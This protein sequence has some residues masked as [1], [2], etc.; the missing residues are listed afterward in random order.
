[1]VLGISVLLIVLM[2][3]ALILAI[4]FL[5]VGLI[6]GRKKGNKEEL[7]VQPATPVMQFQGT[8][9][10]KQ[11]KETDNEKTISI[12]ESQPVSI[13]EEK[14]EILNN[15][16]N[17]EIIKKTYISL[18]DISNPASVFKAPIDTKITVGRSEGD[19]IISDDKSISL[20]HCEI[21]KKDGVFTLRDL[22]SS[23]G[24]FVNGNRIDSVEIK[25]GDL[26]KMGR[27]EFRLEI[28]EE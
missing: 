9:S 1:M 26:I 28:N 8:V 7:N 3:I 5:I 12:F 24:T 18:A 21:E 10:A 22:N 23:N 20:K 6:L 17:T 11:V 19:I 15:F 16:V 2:V 27:M 14:T 13:P 4:V 25:S